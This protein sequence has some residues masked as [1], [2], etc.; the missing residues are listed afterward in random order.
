MAEE[1]GDGL[2]GVAHVFSATEV[3]GRGPPVLEVGNAV[4]DWDAP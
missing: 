2:G 1:A 3:T 4:L